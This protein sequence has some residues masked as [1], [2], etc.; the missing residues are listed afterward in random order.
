[1]AAGRALVRRGPLQLLVPG[2]PSG[3]GDRRA[4]VRRRLL[5]A[6]HRAAPLRDRHP[7]REHRAFRSARIERPVA[8]RIEP[9]RAAQTQHLGLRAD[10]PAGRRP[11]VRR[12]VATFMR[13]TFSTLL[14]AAVL[15]SMPAAAQ[16]RAAPLEADRIVAVVNNEVITRSELDRRLADIVQQAKRQESPLPP[17]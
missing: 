11:R 3:R 5:G 15:G 16:E 4:G 2:Q 12:T 10:Q 9:A 6:A 1:M 17:R 14:L 13:A 8:H 7:D